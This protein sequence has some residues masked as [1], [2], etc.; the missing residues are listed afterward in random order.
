MENVRY[1]MTETRTILPPYRDTRH[2]SQ[3]VLFIAVAISAGMINALQISMLG[4]IKA[5]RGTFES[6]WI[7]NLASLAGMA[8]VLGIV[9][10][11]TG[12]SGLPFPF[13]SPLTYV[14]ISLFMLIGLLLAAQGIAPYLM[15][16]GLAS[17]PFLLSAAYIGPRIGL[18]V[19]FA[20]VVTGQLTGSSLL[21]HVGAFGSTQRT[22]DWVRLLGILVLLLGVVLIRG[23]K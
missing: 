5:E 6:T 22:L 11:A 18:G 10:L 19:Y 8:L 21:D 13:T 2:M 23:R 12:K 4:A 16:T 15:L 9:T 1:H 17:I 20:A 14:V 3:E 7:S